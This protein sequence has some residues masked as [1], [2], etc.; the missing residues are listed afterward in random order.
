ML[1]HGMGGTA[2]RHPGP[3]E[4]Q[5]VSSA[6]DSKHYGLRKKDLHRGQKGKA[7]KDVGPTNKG[8]EDLFQTD[9]LPAK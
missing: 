5:E 6:L 8:G 2:A 3:G 9:C 4:I 1:A 7:A